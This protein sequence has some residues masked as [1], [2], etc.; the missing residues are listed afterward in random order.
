MILNFYP[1]KH[2]NIKAFIP[3][4]C[5]LLLLLHKADAQEYGFNPAL[6]TSGTDTNLLDISA[7]YSEGRVYLKVIMNCTKKDRYYAVKRSVDGNYF[8]TIG[9]IKCNGAPS[10]VEMMYSY[11]D[12]NPVY[13]F[14]YYRIVC[15]SD[16]D[17]LYSPTAGVLAGNDN[18]DLY[19]TI[20][21]DIWIINEKNEKMAPFKLDINTEN[22]ECDASLSPDGNTLYFVSDRAGGYGGKDIW[23]SQMFS[24]GQ[25]SKPYNLGKEINS[26]A[27]ED[28][29][30]IQNDGVTLYFCKKNKKGKIEKAYFST[31]NDNGFWSNRENID[32]LAGETKD[33]FSVIKKSLSGI[34]YIYHIDKTPD[35]KDPKK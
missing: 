7:K 25:W 35:V 10:P 4:I 24:N 20:S 3:F 21:D 26:S 22:S 16:N 1:F 2:I 13:S 33:Y 5:A 34:N 27:D 19:V 9:S 23:A 29:P 15:Y 14:L 12:D 31:Q 8:K 28:F 30:L 32:L 6:R 17:S 11:T 18:S